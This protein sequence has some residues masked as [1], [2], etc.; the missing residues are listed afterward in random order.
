MNEDEGCYQPT[1]TLRWRE[2]EDS[3]D[4]GS[5]VRGTIAGWPESG[6]SYYKLQQLWV[7]PYAGHEPQ[8]RNVPV[9]HS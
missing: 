4:H 5:T 9:D 1:M 2:V 8:W 6:P 3:D 7:S